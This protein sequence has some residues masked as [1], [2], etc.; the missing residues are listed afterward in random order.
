MSVERHE[1]HEQSVGAYLLGALDE[2]ET[3]HF[4]APPRGVPPVP[5]RGRAPAPGGRRA[6]AVGTPL[7]APPAVKAA[8][9]AEVEADLRERGELPA[10]A[11]ASSRACASASP[12]RRVARRHAPGGGV[13]ERGLRADRGRRGRLRAQP[14]HDRTRRRDTGRDR[15]RAQHPGGSGSLLVPGDGRGR[16]PARARHAD[17]STRSPSTRCGSSATARRSP[18]RCSAWAWTATAP[19]RFRR[20]SRA[21]TR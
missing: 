7:P 4:E 11:R 6:G 3:R 20:T 14:G 5:G 21:P 8:L 17:R 13:G 15:R 12:R 10:P 9:M 19:R 2:H 16:D 18:S 1:I